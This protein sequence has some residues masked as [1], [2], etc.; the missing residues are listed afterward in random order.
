MKNPYKEKIKELA[1]L[2]NAKIVLPELNDNRVAEASSI[3]C[4]L[5]FYITDPKE[6]VQNKNKYKEIISKKNFTNNWTENM[7]EDYIQDPFYCSL[8]A[9]ENK[10]VDCVVCGAVKSSTD[11]LRN[12]I[13]VVGVKKDAK[14]VSSTFLMTSPSY[15][16]IYTFSDCAVIPEPTFEQICYIAYQ[17]ASSHKLLTFQEP[18]VAFLS[19]STKNSASHYKV[20]KMKKAANMFSKQF[21]NITY[22]GEI[23]FDVAVDR[24]VAFNKTKD[25]K[26][27]GNANVFIFPDLDAGNIGY[28]ITQYLAGYSAWGPLIQGLEKPVHDLSRGCTVDDIVSVS[29]IAALQ[30]KN[31]YANI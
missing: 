17:A 31:S 4:N 6:L 14:W 7:I 21:P 25:S 1:L 18:K 28:K 29:M 10:D 8:I 11:V 13:R 30:A 15:K 24:K 23:Q 5:G 19:F 20:E 22:E 9:L 16:N 3:L 2:K 12:A 26:L 27:K